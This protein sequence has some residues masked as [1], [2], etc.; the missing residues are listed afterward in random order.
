M[1]LD[2]EAVLAGIVERLRADAR[3]GNVRGE[4]T[5]ERRAGHAQIRVYFTANGEERC[6]EYH[7]QREAPVHTIVRSMVDD[8]IRTLP[9]RIFDGIRGQPQPNDV[10]YPSALGHTPT[11]IPGQPSGPSVL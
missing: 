7:V 2:L 5:G 8:T 6:F 9:Q 4:L 11:I 3:F 1:R 10:Y